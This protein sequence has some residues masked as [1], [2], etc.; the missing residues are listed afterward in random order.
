VKAQEKYRR[1]ATHEF[2]DV[3]TCGLPKPERRNRLFAMLVA[4]IDDSGSEGQGPVF[5]LAGYVADIDQWKDFADEW[6]IAL[7]LR[8][9]LK[10]LKIQEA[11]RGEELWGR[12]K[13]EDRDKRMKRFAA[14]I[15]RHVRFGIVA[16]VAWEDMRK[17][18][19]EFPI[20]KDMPYLMLYHQLISR[21]TYWILEE[22]M[23]QK[24]DFIFDEQGRFGKIATESFLALPLD[25]APEFQRLIGGPPIHRS[26]KEFLP[27]QAA[28]TIAW[29]IRRY[30]HD[31]NLTSDLSE[32]KPIQPHLRKLGAIDMLWTWL[33][34]ERMAKRFRKVSAAATS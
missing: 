6:K 13:K 5:I 17:L 23:D 29:L 7:E 3:L 28:H 27:L 25:L 26:D 24:I 8:P 30:A 4:H 10:R 9:K 18:Q 2:L 14:I 22:N 19:E 20:P 32:W 15:H 21:V 16:S 31:N 11:I 33:D 12:T 34:Y 1:N